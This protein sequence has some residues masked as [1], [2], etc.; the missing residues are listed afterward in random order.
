MTPAH[1]YEIFIRAS[2]ERVWNALIDPEYTTQY[3]HGTRFESSFEPGAP[4]VSRIVEQDRPAVDGTIE[5]FEPPSR[6]VYTWHALYDDEMAAEPPSRVEWTLAPATEDGAVTRVTMRH[7]DLG[8]SPKTWES[9]RIG[10]VAIIDSLKSLL[11]T[12]EPLP[13][14][15]TGDRAAVSEIDGKWHRMQG[16]AAN[17]STWELLDGRQLTDDEGDDLLGRAYAAT[18][19]WRRAEGATAV[20]AGAR[21]MARVAQPC[22]ARPRRAGAAPCPAVECARA[23]GRRPRR[24]LRPRLRPRGH[25]PGARLP[26]SARRGTRRVRARRR[27]RDRRPRGPSDHRIRPQIRALVRA[28]TE[29]PSCQGAARPCP[30][31]LT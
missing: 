5:V 20:N 13:S 8:M 31:T 1:V 2:R 25:G 16:V 21:V 14:V 23:G 12:G 28:L 17:N 3:F 22:C 6:L 15:G 10:W 11:E 4:Y 19:H 7:G 26:R 29:I 9:V 30:H 18:Y 24:R 27:G